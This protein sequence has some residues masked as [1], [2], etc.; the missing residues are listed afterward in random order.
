MSEDL[1]SGL[2]EAGAL[3]IF[4]ALP[5]NTRQQIFKD[6][7]VVRLSPGDS[8][9]ATLQDP[10]CALLLSGLARLSATSSEGRMVTVRYATAGDV[11]GLISVLNDRQEVAAHAITKCEAALINVQVLRRLAQSDPQVALLL[12]QRVADIV[13]Q[14]IELM[15]INIFGTVRRR[16]SRH[17]LDLAESRGRELV[18]TSDQ[19]QIANAIGS[20][21]EVVARAL[22]SMEQDGLIRRETVRIVLLDPTGL[23]VSADGYYADKQRPLNLL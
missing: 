12:A 17:L 14:V 10:R 3:S 21:R 1:Q 19:Q 5:P 16:V 18:V 13:G 7:H 15:S 20:V 4:G 11:V 9:Y 2:S 22:R 6:A 23:H 8:I